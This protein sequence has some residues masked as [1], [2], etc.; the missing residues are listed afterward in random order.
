MKKYLSLGSKIIAILAAI[1]G[2]ILSIFATGEFMTGSQI[3]LYFTIQSNLMIAIYLI[4]EIIFEYIIK[5]HYRV[6]DTLKLMFTVAISLTG[7]VFSFVLAPTMENAF[8]LP[9]TLTHVVS[10]LF[11]I[12]DFFL[13][14]K[15]KYTF[16]SNLLSTIPPLYY[17]FF[18]LI[19]YFLNWNFGGGN[20]YPYFF[21]NW[22]SPAGA[23]GF[24][25]ELPFIGVFYW[26]LILLGLV[27]GMSYIYTSINNR[28]LKNK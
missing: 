23:F 1:I 6:M 3:F 7:I 16:K 26:V 9:N 11:S 22:G 13:I 8:T 18:S 27:I 15:E 5:K 4:I 28:R 20:N 25:N 21:L 24:T 12:V 2:T 14:K 10:P 19:G 17:L